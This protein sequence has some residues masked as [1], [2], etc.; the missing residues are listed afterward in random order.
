MHTVILVAGVAHPDCAAYVG[1]AQHPD[2]AAVIAVHKFNAATGA[3]G[4]DAL[5][6]STYAQLYALRGL[7]HNGG[8]WGE[9]YTHKS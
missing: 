1:V 9:V 4:C 6:C 8:D 5:T 2:D 7:V 3:T